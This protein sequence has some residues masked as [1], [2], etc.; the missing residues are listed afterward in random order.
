[1]SYVCLFVHGRASAPILV[2]AMPSGP[3][4]TSDTADTTTYCHYLLS[5]PTAN[6]TTTPVVIPT[7]TV[8]ENRIYS[9]K[10]TCGDRYP[11]EAPAVQFLSK[12]NLP[13]VSQSN[14]K[15]RGGG[16]RRRRR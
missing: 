6:T 15:V 12:I 13:C 3:D 10:I 14:G 5:L 2:P 11:D 9:L 1:M 7:Q 4:T 8:H 16:L